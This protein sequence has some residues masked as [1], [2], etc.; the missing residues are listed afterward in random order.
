MTEAFVYEHNNEKILQLKFQRK[1]VDYSNVYPIIALDTSGSMSS[2]ISYAL[3]G[4][5]NLAEIY[6]D[7]KCKQISVL[8]YNSNVSPKMFNNK[9][10]IKYYNTYPTN[11]TNFVKI[12]NEITFSSNGNSNGNKKFEIFF[13]TDGQ[14]TVNSKEILQKSITKFKETVKYPVNVIG[15]TN[16]HDIY[17]LNA[18]SSNGTYQYADSPESLNDIIS[19]L[20]IISQNKVDF[21]GK[22]NNVPIKGTAM[23]N[24]ENN[25]EYITVITGIDTSQNIINIDNKSIPIL[26]GNSNFS[27]DI[28]MKY[29]IN[30]LR[31]KINVLVKASI[32]NEN[33][34]SY[35]RSVDKEIDNLT[36][37]IFSQKDFFQIDPSKRKFLKT[38][39]LEFKQ[40]I[41]NLYRDRV[42][43]LNTVERA[44]MLSAT[45]SHITKN[46][47]LKTLTNRSNDSNINDHF[48]KANQAAADIKEPFETASDI[49]SCMLSLNTFDELAKQG[50]C[51]CLCFKRKITQASIVDPSQIVI[52]YISPTFISF[53]SFKDIIDLKLLEQN[54]SIG[55][56]NRSRPILEGMAREGINAV[57]PLWINSQHWSVA[58]HLLP[59]ALSYTSTNIFTGYAF[60]QMKIVPFIIYFNALKTFISVKSPFNKTILDHVHAIC[61]ALPE[62]I[63]KEYIQEIEKFKNPEFRTIDNC[64]SLE[65]LL[66]ASI[67]YKKPLDINYVAEEYHRRQQRWMY[68][69]GTNIIKTCTDK[70]HLNK[71]FNVD[72]LVITSS[73]LDSNEILS[74]DIIDIKK[75]FKELFDMVNEQ[76]NL[77]DEQYFAIM[78]QNT[79]HY[80]NTL[81]RESIQ[82]NEYIDPI[83]DPIK[84]IKYIGAKCIETI[85][86]EY[87]NYIGLNCAKMFAETSVENAKKL[88]SINVTH[89][90]NVK[91]N[92][93]ALALA[94]E[95]VSFPLEKINILCNSEKFTWKPKINWF[96]KWYKNNNVVI[97][98]DILIHKFNIP[99]LRV[100][101]WNYQIIK[102]KE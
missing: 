26:P 33:Y 90:G 64:S 98:K 100:D 5:K 36:T 60:L 57:I 44:T 10:E 82:N 58:K 39:H 99:E 22:I 17:V 59:V 76:D 8:E 13:L 102:D 38:I 88:F 34:D 4:I 87:Q 97:T 25:L 12:I 37:N 101:L 2:V 86:K 72:N 75:I 74:G 85:E 68:P 66:A 84:T 3:S 96:Y 40:I 27:A 48:N 29:K 67:I 92:M 77:S 7:N 56:F 61:L 28:Y 21:E 30:S 9:N 95:N 19:N 53:N 80:T 41:G 11:T 89:I 71:I 24:D 14:D 18:L 43:K 51:L 42:S 79:L 6:F 46:H 47:I 45:S 63:S 91:L 54:S 20:T 69:A 49:G 94:E 32:N 31:D 15:F 65:A 78:L 52:E 35:L 62:S 70:L 81:R 23:C 1:T 83:K 73:V 93:F 50:D 55:E 16:S